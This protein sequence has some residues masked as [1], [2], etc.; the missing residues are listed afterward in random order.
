MV[1]S[2][3]DDGGEAD[4]V[5]P[6]RR[7]CS[8]PR[9][10]VPPYPYSSRE[11]PRRSPILG[12]PTAQRCPEIPSERPGTASEP[13]A[14]SG[15]SIQVR[16]KPAE[17]RTGQAAFD[18]RALRRADR[19]VHHER[20]RMMARTKRSRRS[21]GAGEWGRNRVRVFPIPRPTCSRSSGARTGGGSPGR[22]GTG[23]GTGRRSRR[24]SSPP[25][26]R[27]RT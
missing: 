8:V 26:S 23:T 25:G 10:H 12:C 24:M 14:A 13:F 5:T 22:L 11:H 19:A 9:H 27:A 16:P 18:M 17:P 3:K 2:P 20:N 7:R 21:Y 1:A 15:A 4:H 6:R